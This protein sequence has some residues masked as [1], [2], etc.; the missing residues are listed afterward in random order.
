M[1]RVAD[2]GSDK[3]SCHKFFMTIFLSVHHV[4]RI[5]NIGLSGILLIDKSADIYYFLYLRVPYSFY[6]YHY[7]FYYIFF[8][9]DV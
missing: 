6:A 3:S 2:P 8:N 9:K 5:E 4:K 7:T 1:S